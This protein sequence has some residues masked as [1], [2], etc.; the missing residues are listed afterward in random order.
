MTGECDEWE[1]GLGVVLYNVR[2]DA[3]PKQRDLWQV[4]GRFLDVDSGR[5]KYELS[6]RTH[7][8]RQYYWATAVLEDFDPAGWTLPVTVSPSE[9]VGRQTVDRDF[10]EYISKA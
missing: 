3:P 8:K 5:R 4:T 9:V 1:L 2:Y 6:N 7:T 10:D